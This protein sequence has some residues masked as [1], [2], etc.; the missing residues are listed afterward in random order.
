MLVAVVV[1]LAMTMCAIAAHDSVRQYLV[2]GSGEGFAAAQVEAAK[3]EG[4]GGAI[5]NEAVRQ[6]QTLCQCNGLIL[7]QPLSRER[8][9]LQPLHERPAPLK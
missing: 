1:K 3:E 7:M 4:A 2:H 5:S 6:L 8:V 9:D